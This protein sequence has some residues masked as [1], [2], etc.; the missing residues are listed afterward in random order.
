MS[1]STCKLFK[2]DRLGQHGTKGPIPIETSTRP[3]YGTWKEAA[4]ELGYKVTDPNGPQTEGKKLLANNARGMDLPKEV[5][6]KYS[7]SHSLC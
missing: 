7:I 5:C 3:I 4:A 2:N 1:M 6:Q